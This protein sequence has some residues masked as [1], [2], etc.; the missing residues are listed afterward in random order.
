M[1]R[2]L[3]DDLGHTRGKSSMGLRSVKRPV[4]R[5]VPVSVIVESG[6]S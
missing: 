1:G 2:I 4:P 5:V 6:R 3:E